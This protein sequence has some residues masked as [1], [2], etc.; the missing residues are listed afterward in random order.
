MP[1]LAH[2]SEFDPLGADLYHDVIEKVWQDDGIVPWKTAEEYRTIVEFLDAVPPAI[3]ANIGRWFLQKR[4]DLAQGHITPSGL[5]VIGDDR[6]VFACS[7][8]VGWRDYDDWLSELAAVATLRHSQALETGA[9]DSTTTML[10]GALIDNGPSGGI[11]YSFVLLRSRDA[12]AP[13]PPDLR[14]SFEWRYGLHD[15]GRM[16]TTPL[17][18]GPKDACP[19]LGGKLFEECC[20]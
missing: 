18:V 17:E 2:E 9:P 11:S 20:G 14:R 13:L 19:C 1:F 6:L 8:I 16:R 12:L 4:R 3:Q 10:V 15:H 7:N 5:A